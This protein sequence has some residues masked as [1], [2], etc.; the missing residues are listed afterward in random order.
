MWGIIATWR[1]AVEGI[2]KASEMLKEGANAGDAIE[3]AIREVEDFPYYKSVGYGGLP[4]EE[5]VVE[6]DAAYMDGDTLDIGAIAAIKDFANPVSIAK[7][8]SK[9]KVNNLLVGEGAEKFAHKEGFERKTMLTDRA[10]IHYKNR[11]KEIKD[12]EIKPYSGHDTVGMVC[13]DANGK[14]TSA[15]STSG[16]FMKKSGRVGDSPISGS[17]F[18]VDSKVGG[19]SATGLGEDLMKGCVSYEIV[20]LMKEG[21]H[22]QD[23]CEKAVNMFDLELKERRGKAGDMSL[24]AM[25]NKGE[26]GVATNIEGFSFAVATENEEPTVYLTKNVDGKCIHE[27]AS[28][29][30]LD[31]YMQTR[32]APLVE[33]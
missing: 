30:W 23:A 31:N 5:M 24:V 10:K 32:M 14:M 12:L 3:T 11:L 27:V 8:L 29:E 25:N 4:N 18:Y 16:L 15:T 9:E 22:P 21:M 2:T 13:L 6:L 28:Q 26:W 20:R 17:G 1:K 19:A 7:R 33:K